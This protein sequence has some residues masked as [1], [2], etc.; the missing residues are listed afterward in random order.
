MLSNEEAIAKFDQL[1]EAWLMQFSDGWWAFY[2]NEKPL[3]PFEIKADACRAGLQEWGDH[4][5]EAA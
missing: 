2:P 4:L 5:E 1:K 3:G